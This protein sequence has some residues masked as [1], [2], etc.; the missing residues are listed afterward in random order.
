MFCITERGEKTVAYGQVPKV[1]SLAKALRLL[2]C[3]T[4]LLLLLVQ[5]L[6]LITVRL[7]LHHSVLFPLFVFVLEQSEYYVNGE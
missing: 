5:S 1:K 2:E 3:F 4:T 6:M 7:V